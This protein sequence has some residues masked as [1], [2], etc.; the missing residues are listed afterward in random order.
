MNHVC[1]LPAT[2]KLLFGE[3]NGHKWNQNRVDIIK[4]LQILTLERKRI[5]LESEKKV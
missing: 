2:T 1:E 4:I 5:K 3:A